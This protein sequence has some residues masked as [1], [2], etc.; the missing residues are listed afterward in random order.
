MFDVKEV[1]KEAE[2]EVREEKAKEAKAKIKAKLKEI[3]RA[4]KVVNNMEREYEVLL[5][6]IGADVS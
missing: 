4:R 5:S 2:K 3:E 1:V 6:D